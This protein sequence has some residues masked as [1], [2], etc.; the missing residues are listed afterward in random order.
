MMSG[1]LKGGGT[2][3]EAGSSFQVLVGLAK[4]KLFNSTLRG[5]FK[6]IHEPGGS[7]CKP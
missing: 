7:G 3:S 6:S 2:V 5:M 1:D 4:K